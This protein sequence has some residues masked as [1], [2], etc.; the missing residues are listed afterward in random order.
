VTFEIDDD[1]LLLIWRK[2]IRFDCPHCGGPHDSR[3]GASYVEDV[4]AHHPPGD[5]SSG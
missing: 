2:P 4:L 3:V 1:S 5:R